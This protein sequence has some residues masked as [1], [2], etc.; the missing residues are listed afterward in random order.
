MALLMLATLWFRFWY[1]VWPL[2]LAAP[3][4]TTHR[5]LA[6]SG[7]AFSGSALLVYLFTDYLWVWY[8]TDLK[9][10]LI[11][12]AVMFAPPLAALAAGAGLR[13]LWQGRQ[14]ETDFAG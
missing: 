4:V 13:H 10:H 6:A 12:M 5:W 1:V 9:L 2:A 3:L 8:G 7:I 11:L 14:A